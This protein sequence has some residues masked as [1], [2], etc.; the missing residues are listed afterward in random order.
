MQFS[1]TLKLRNARMLIERLQHRQPVDDQ[2][3]ASTLGKV[4]WR[5]LQQEISAMED[6]LHEQAIPI[7]VV[8]AMRHY[9]ERLAKADQ[10]ERKAELTKPSTR[11]SLVVKRQLRLRGKLHLLRKSSKEIYR[12]RAETQYERAIETLIEVIEEFPDVVS[13][14]NK[15]PIFDGEAFNVNPDPEGVPRLRNSRSRHNLSRSLPKQSIK[16]IKIDA[17]ER[18]IFEIK[19]AQ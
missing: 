5:E 15:Y 1:K 14:L 11:P 9:N 4:R 19:I 10:L 17:L 7:H 2:N 13:H 12:I 16:Q 18:L 3:L 6:R 8:R